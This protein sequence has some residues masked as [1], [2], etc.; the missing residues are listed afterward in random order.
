MEGWIKLHRKIVD[1][2]YYFAEAFTRSQAW[3]DLLILANHKDNFFYIRGVKIDVKRGQIGFALENLG[4][5]WKWSR[6]KVER[7]ISELETSSQIVRQK[8]NVTTLL[9]IVNYDTYQQDGKANDN[10]SSKP[11]SKTDEHQTVKQTDINKNVNNDN[12]EKNDKNTLFAEIEISAEELKPVD[13]NFLEKE[14]TAFTESINAEIKKEDAIVFVQA[15]VWPTFDD[16]WTAYD[17]KVGKPKSKKLWDKIKQSEKEEIM[18]HVP[19][20]VAS[21]Q[22]EKFR[23]HPT[24]YLSNRAWEDQ[25]IN[26]NTQKNAKQSNSELA[27]FAFQAYQNG[28]QSFT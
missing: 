28:K 13:D 18:Q 23:K 7:F 6:G 21:T 27:D 10:A 14:K 17:K 4:K 5:R 2:P 9:S 16:F 25:I 12:N 15:E 26:S 8:N 19:L 11:N 20:Y 3:V 1:N 24:T 22:E